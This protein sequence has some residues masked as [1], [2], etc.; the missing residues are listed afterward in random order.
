MYACD[1]QTSRC[2]GERV[3]HI[4]SDWPGARSYGFFTG[5]DQTAALAGASFQTWVLGNGLGTDITYNSQ[6]YYSLANYNALGNAP[7]SVNVAMVAA[8]ADFGTGSVGGFVSQ[9]TAVPE[10]QA[11][12]LA[13]MG[14]ALAGWANR[15]R[16]RRLGLCRV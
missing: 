16:R 15:T 2:H 1:F 4:G 6:S 7:L 10:P 14:M 8:S 9:V 3:H 11:W 12:L 13:T 5:S